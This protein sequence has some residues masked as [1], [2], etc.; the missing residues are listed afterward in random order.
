MGGKVVGDVLVTLADPKVLIA[1][2]LR[3]YLYATKKSRGTID[4]SRCAIKCI[5]HD[6][7]NPNVGMLGLEGRKQVQRELFFGGILRVGNRF[8]RPLF[9][10]D[11]LLLEGFGRSIPRTELRSG[12]IEDNAHGNRDF[13]GHP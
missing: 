11:T 10:G 3:D 5:R 13:W 9:W 1:A 12:L 4:K 6:R 7:A 8:A 2:D